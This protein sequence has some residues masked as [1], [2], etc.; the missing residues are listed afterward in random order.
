MLGGWDPIPYH[1]AIVNDAV[2]PPY[3]FQ[4]PGILSI[5]SIGGGSSGTIDSIDANTVSPAGDNL[6]LN[7]G[8]STNDLYSEGNSS[9]YSNSV[10]ATSASDLSS[11]FYAKFHPDF[12][13]I[14]NAVLLGNNK[15]GDIAG[16]LLTMQGISSVGNSLL[17]TANTYGNTEVYNLQYINSKMDTVNGNIGTANSWLS[18]I[19]TLNSSILSQLQTGSGSS[20]GS[21]DLSGVRSDIQANTSTLKASIESAVSA[22]LDEQDLS[23]GDMSDLDTLKSAADAHS[24]QSKDLCDAAG[25]FVNKVQQSR[26]FTLSKIQTFFGGMVGSWAGL[27]RVPIDSADWGFDFEGC[28]IPIKL[29]LGDP[30]LKLLIDKTRAIEVVMLWVFFATRVMSLFSASVKVGKGES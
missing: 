24:Q 27:G 18:Q 7:D 2:V 11:A 1:L 22:D 23:D 4:N 21:V 9:S 14:G 20:G 10:S 25:N 6:I 28:H 26:S 30:R 13:T 5:G 15:V 16:T 8:T 3:L 29:D 19:K 17:T 12:A